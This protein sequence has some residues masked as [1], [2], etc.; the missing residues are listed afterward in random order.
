MM[1]RVTPDVIMFQAMDVQARVVLHFQNLMTLFAG[2]SAIGSG[3]AL[4]HFYAVLFLRKHLYFEANQLT[5]LNSLL[6]ALALLQHS[7]F[8]NSGTGVVRNEKAKSDCHYG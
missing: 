7:F 5:A 3:I 1:S 4:R 6:D 8:N 2:Q